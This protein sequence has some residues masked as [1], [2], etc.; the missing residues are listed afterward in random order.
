VLLLV[1]VALGFDPRV[2]AGFEV[3]DKSKHKA[4]KENPRVVTGDE[5]HPVLWSDPA[6]IETLDLFYGSGGSEGAPD[7]SGKFTYVDAVT[8][9]T[10]KKIH[11]KDNQGRDWTVKFGSEARPETSAARFVWAMGYH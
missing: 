11:V 1:I 10:Q 8:R 7:P 5:G 2:L 3:Q 9:G 4:E 6:N